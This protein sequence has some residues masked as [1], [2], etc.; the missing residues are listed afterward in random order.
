MVSVQEC[1]ESEVL[2]VKGKTSYRRESG[3]FHYWSAT[4]DLLAIAVRLTMI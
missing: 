1:P 4:I 3:W 2:E